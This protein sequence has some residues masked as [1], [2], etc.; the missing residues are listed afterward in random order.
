MK[1]RSVVSLF[2]L[3]ISLLLMSGC[4]SKEL[5]VQMPHH[6]P[7]GEQGYLSQIEP[8]R[9]ALLS[10]K[11]H[12][13]SMEGKREALGVEMG[14]VVFVPHAVEVIRDVIASELKYAGHDVTNKE[15][16][17][18]VAMRVQVKNFDATTDSTM[19]YWDINGYTKIA[20]EVLVDGSY[21]T[22]SFASRCTDRTYVWPSA[23]LFKKVMLQCMDDFSQKFRNDQA[24]AKAIERGK[25]Q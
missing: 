9:V 2:V 10:V 20:V 17:Q 22:F 8:Q 12:R 19:T 18:T 7:S 16:D 11:D 13:A 25:N 3:C 24:L 21:E 15:S 23:D 1:R 6:A 5:A 4:A 14:A